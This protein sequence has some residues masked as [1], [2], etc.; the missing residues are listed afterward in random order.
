MLSKTRKEI[1]LAVPN[2]FAIDKSKASRG[3]VILDC[4]DII[5]SYRVRVRL[6]EGS[7]W[8]TH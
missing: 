7:G 8:C 6:T 2:S 4:Q 3:Q 5:M 1:S